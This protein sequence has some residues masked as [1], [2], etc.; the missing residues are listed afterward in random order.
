MHQQR[1]LAATAAIVT[2]SAL[3]FTGCSSGGT[4]GGGSAATGEPIKVAALAGLTYFPESSEAAQAVF[5][6][7]NAAGGLD[8]RPIEYTVY[9]DKTDPAAAATAAQ[10]ALTSGAVALVGGASLLDCA[11]NHGTWEENNIVSI[12]GTGVD[13]YCFATPNIAPTNTG[14][15]FDTFATLTMGSEQLGFENICTLMTPD[16]AAAKAAYEQAIAAWSAATGKELSYFDSSL[17]RSQPNYSGNVSKLK[18]QTC[19]AVFI[20]ENGDAVAKIL[21]EMTNQGITLPVVT[22]T[23]FYSD[24]SAM[25]ANYGGDIYLPAEWAPY[26]DESI[27][28]VSDWTAAMDAH[29]V[30]KT[31]FSQGGYLAAQNFLTILATVDGDVTRDSF[32]EAAKGMTDPIDS[33]MAQSS[34]F[35]GD[36]D[37][38]QPNNTAYPVVLRTGTTAWES[39]GPLLEG[40]QLGWVPTTVPAGS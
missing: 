28:G 37:F 18:S 14:P 10:D 2:A 26:N 20:S 38:H 25:S 35:F 34:Y 40:D 11:V 17:V 23:S 5:D 24:E 7:F 16:E 19:D 29:R 22:L 15:Y 8:G 1:T 12:Q 13:P 4:S 31:A 36:A 21:G 30:P 33:P 6:D 3:A 32:T 27:G 9:D 39:L